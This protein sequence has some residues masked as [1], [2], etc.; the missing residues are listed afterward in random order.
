M[1]VRPTIMGKTTHSRHERQFP[2][3]KES[4]LRW[5][6]Q[7]NWARVFPYLH[8]ETM[9]RRFL[10]HFITEYARSN[11][12]EYQLKDDFTGE[13]Y[14]FNVYHSAQTVLAGVHKRNMDPFSRKNRNAA[15]NGRFEFGYGDDRCMVSVCELIFFR[16]A[17]KHRVLEYAERHRQ[18]IIDD[19][20]SMSRAK[21]HLSPSRADADDDGDEDNGNGGDDD[22]DE[23]T[24]SQ[25]EGG[26]LLH[27]S[28]SSLALVE[29]EIELPVEE[30]TSAVA[31]VD[32]K[33]QQQQ[34]QQHTAALFRDEYWQASIDE[35]MIQPKK[36]RRRIRGSAVT[37]LIND[38]C[39]IKAAI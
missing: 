17:V 34:Q 10:E 22:G 36:R 33:L 39:E 35:K 37:M 9:S 2:L 27:L 21:R 7:A 32:K 16:W 13:I 26:S 19:M 5:Y 11:H 4:V 31:V 23:V 25:E 12:C 20:R 8:S 29:V 24:T 38:D 18:A 28:S 14:N 1:N 6:T 30:T 15:N 3:F